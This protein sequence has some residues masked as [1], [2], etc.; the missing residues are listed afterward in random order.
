MKPTRARNTKARPDIRAPF[1]GMDT[2][3][4]A[5]RTESPR[6]RFSDNRPG[7]RGQRN[8]NDSVR[9]R[10]LGKIDSSGRPVP[11]GST[12]RSQRNLRT[13]QREVINPGRVHQTIDTRAETVGE[14]RR[15]RKLV[16]QLA[17]PA[18]RQKQTSRSS[19]PQ[20]P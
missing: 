12:G 6:A 18:R 19:K 10:N 7:D 14:V 11:K 3:T 16:K 17:A 5:R 4:I 15:R 9:D 20:T 8:K 2:Q 1:P 13:A